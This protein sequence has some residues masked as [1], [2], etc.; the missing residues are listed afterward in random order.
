MIAAR[1]SIG[2]N[3]PT[4]RKR[5]R[6]G[7]AGESHTIEE[8]QRDT[9]IR[10]E[11]DRKRE[12]KKRTERKKKRARKTPKKPIHTHN[13]QFLGFKL[14][15]KIQNNYG[16]SLFSFDARAF[17]SIGERLRSGRYCAADE[18]SVEKKVACG[19]ASC[20]F[21]VVGTAAA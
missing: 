8:T 13:A 17:N 9:G 10:K 16:I 4:K 11:R 6:N 7:F 15:T 20:R 2:R 12:M 14:N 3:G 21:C 1:H 5:P 19:C 18:L